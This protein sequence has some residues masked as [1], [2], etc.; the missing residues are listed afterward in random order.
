MDEDQSNPVRKRVRRNALK[1]NSV[2]SDALREFGLLHTL[3]NKIDIN[4]NDTDRCESEKRPR[5]LSEVPETN[6]EV[7]PSESVCVEAV[8]VIEVV[9]PI[10]VNAQPLREDVVIATLEIQQQASSDSLSVPDLQ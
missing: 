3:S 7:V 5:M 2:E 1:P 9:Q 6:S 10:E 8:E 4:D